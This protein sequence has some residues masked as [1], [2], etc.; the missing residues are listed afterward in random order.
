MPCHHKVSTLRLGLSG[1]CNQDL[2]QS[3][4]LTQCPQR[5]QVWA[6]PLAGEGWPD[7]SPVDFSVFKDSKNITMCCIS[8]TPPTLPISCLLSVRAGFHSFLPSKLSGPSREEL[9]VWF[10]PALSVY[11]YSLEFY[12]NN[13]VFPLSTLLLNEVSFSMSL[14]CA[15]NLHFLQFVYAIERSHIIL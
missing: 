13:E 11:E 10:S 8:L 3:P 12:L 15:E 1:L 7:D 9:V 5:C 4:P 14:A 6:V 2:F